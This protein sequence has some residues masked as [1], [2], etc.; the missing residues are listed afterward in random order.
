M[1]DPIMIFEVSI[2]SKD[3]TQMNCPY[4]SISI[5]PFHAKVTSELFTGETLPGAVDVQ[6]ENAAGIRNMSARYA[7]RGIDS[8]GNPCTLFVDNEAWFSGSRKHEPVIHA[9]P[10]FLTDSPALGPYLCQNRFRAEVRSAP[11]GVEIWVYDILS[12]IDD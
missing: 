11:C 2:D 10:R 9:C 7:F 5:L 4:G 3:V 6:Q 1:S 12:R 8:E